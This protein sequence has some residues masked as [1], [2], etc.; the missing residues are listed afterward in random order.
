MKAMP[1]RALISVSHK[2]GLAAFAKGLI[3]L[4]F[5]VLSTGGTARALRQEGIVHQEVSEVTGFPEI[6]DGRVK[7]LHPMIHGGLLARRDLPRHMQELADHRI[8]PI[9]VVAVNLYPFEQTISK[10]DCSLEEAVEQIDIGGPTLLRAA[11]KNFSHVTVVVDPADYS[12]VLEELRSEG[13]RVSGALRRRLAQKVFSHTAHYDSLIARYLEKTEKGE[14][15][16]S[17]PPSLYLR[18]EKV[19]DLRYGENPHQR[20]AFYRDPVCLEPSVAHSQQLQGKEMSY[21]NYLDAHAALELAREFDEP[22]AVIVKHNN[23]CGVAV[24]ENLAESYRKARATDPV[25][26]FGGVVAFNRPVDGETA[27]EVCTTFMEVVAA[28]GFEPEALEHF[29]KKKSLRLINL[30]DDLSGPLGGAS[31]AVI[32]RLDFRRISGGLLLQDRDLGRLEDIRRLKV[33]TKRHPSPQEYEALALAWKVVKHVKSNAIVYATVG[34]ALGIGAGQ[35]SRVDS[36]K[37]GAMKAVL[38]LHG[39]A[40]ASDAFFPFRDGIDAAAEA[41]IA[42]IIQPGGS[43]RDEEITT[44]ADEHHLAM[45]FTGMRHFRH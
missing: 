41:G 17:F 24:A 44:A 9:D 43:I 5:S 36:V 40:L 12:K 11:A 2:E 26:A 6:L 31:K 25:S 45:V 34:Q 38:P 30:G 19:Q 33:V 22:V 21:N 13:G 35:M 3:E 10:S 23:P 7:T 42:A 1:K 32:E 27:S 39:S 37:L 29:S 8:T 14:E 18:Y 20:S 16:L 15:A 4:G 28:P